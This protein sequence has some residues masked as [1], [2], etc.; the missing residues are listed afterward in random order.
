MEQE[1]IKICGVVTEEVIRS[2][3][4]SMYRIRAG[5][6]EYD[7]VSAGKQG[8]KDYLFVRKG[9]KMEV[10]GCEMS[11]EYRNELLAQHTKIYIDSQEK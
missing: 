7:I 2:E 10:D 3:T 9:Q 11:K 1:H 4:K 8:I 5:D 6:T